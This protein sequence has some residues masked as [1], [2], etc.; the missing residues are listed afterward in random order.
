[1][2]QRSSPSSRLRRT[3]GGPC[4]RALLEEAGGLVKQGGL[5]MEQAGI[6]ARKVPCLAIQ[7]AC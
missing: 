4:L 6:L 2:T 7:A 1:M 5:F 3:Y